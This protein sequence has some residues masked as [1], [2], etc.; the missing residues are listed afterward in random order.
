MKNEVNNI[1]SLEKKMLR[2]VRFWLVMLLPITLILRLIVSNVPNAADFYCDHI[3]RYV[4]VIFN[5]LSG[6]VPFSLAEFVFIGGILAILVYIVSL[7]VLVIRRKGKR[8]KELRNGILNLICLFSVILFLFNTNCGLNYY[9]SGFEQLSGLKTTPV[10]ADTLYD[11]CVYLAKNA[12][13]SGKNVDR[14]ENGVMI[15]NDMNEIK[16]LAADAVNGLNEKYDFIYHGYSIP[17][18]VLLSRG[19]SRLNITGIY[20]PFTFEANVNTDVPDFSIPATMCHELSHVRG[21]MHEEDA[22]FVAFL[23][24]TLS[25]RDELN[26][27]GDMLALSYASNALYSADKE[28]YY[29]LIQNYYTDEM[30]SDLRASAEYWKQFETPVAET[31]AKINDSYLKSNSQSDGVKSYGRMVDLVI[32][33]YCSEIQ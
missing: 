12:A 3:Y 8:I 28:R 6:V 25:D 29:E 1:K 23:A 24:C 4:S 9:R 10:A 20:F 33:Y 21:F 7:V 11:T 30:L 14:D 22:N 17:K 18:G 2:S 19:M 27:S 13:R 15:L 26:Y 5:N 16:H 32:A 31:A